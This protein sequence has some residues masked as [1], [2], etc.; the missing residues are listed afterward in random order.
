MWIFKSCFLELVSTDFRFFFTERFVLTRSTIL[1]NMLVSEMM[2]FIWFLR[3]SSFFEKFEFFMLTFVRTFTLARVYRMFQKNFGGYS[4]PYSSRK[5]TQIEIWTHERSPKIDGYTLK[6][7]ICG[8]GSLG[9]F[10]LQPYYSRGE[11]VKFYSTSH[12]N[13][14]ITFSRAGFNRF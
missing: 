5:W 10:P 8:I 11:N 14:Q 4:E 9:P 13:F 6:V 12:V 7:P 2:F 3:F 1:K